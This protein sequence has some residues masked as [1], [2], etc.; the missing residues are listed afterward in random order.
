MTDGIPYGYCRCGCGRKTDLATC[1]RT[2]LG[3]VKGEPLRFCRGHRSLVDPALRFWPKVDK[4]S[5]PCGCWLWTSVIAPTGYG[6]FAGGRG[7]MVYAHRWAYEATVGPIPDGLV[8]D[9]LCRNTRCVNP[10][11]LEAVT[12][13]VNTHRGDKA[14]IKRDGRCQKDLHDV[15]KDA[16]TCVECRNIARGKRRRRARVQS[17]P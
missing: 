15:P 16:P 4:V 3:Q 13:R 5:S 10:D 17:E 6:M 9:H 11:H 12:Q 2:K 14:T 8:I 1:S 7:A